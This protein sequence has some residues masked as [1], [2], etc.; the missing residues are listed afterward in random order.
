MI[1]EI[2]AYSTNRHRAIH[3]AGGEYTLA[4][5]GTALFP[6]VLLF[7]D[8]QQ[9]QVL[10]GWELKMPNTPLT[11]PQLIENATKKPTAEFKELCFMERAGSRF[12]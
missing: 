9:G 4:G 2:N 11:D 1:T 7:G 6:D 5:E 8:Q 3:R 12:I 10:Q